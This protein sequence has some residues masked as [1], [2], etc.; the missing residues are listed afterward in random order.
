MEWFKRLFNT[1]KAT[2]RPRVVNDPVTWGD[3]CSKQ[4]TWKVDPINPWPDPPDPPPIRILNEDV[5]CY[6]S[7]DGYQPKSSSKTEDKIESHK[8]PYFR[9]D[10]YD[11][12]SSEPSWSKGFYQSVEYSVE[13]STWSVYDYY[14]IEIEYMTEEE[15]NNLPDYEE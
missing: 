8:K 9:V 10:F 11:Q 5:G 13:L 6:G 3:I 4:P 1:K 12:F 2:S 7:I 14:D 15:F